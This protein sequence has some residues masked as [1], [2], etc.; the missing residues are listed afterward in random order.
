MSF[1]FVL[2]QEQRPLDPVHPGR[3]R[4]LLRAGHA[5]VWRRYPFT[6]ILKDRTAEEQPSQPLRLKIDPGSRTT[7]LA[8]VHD[9]SGQVVWAGELTHRGEKVKENLDQRRACRR[10]RRQRLTRAAG[11]PD[12]APKATSVVGGFR[13]GD[14][15]RAVVPPSST[16][17][18]TYVGRIAIRATGSC[19]LKTASGT[20]EGIH[21]RYC[22]P[23]LRGDG[24]S[25]A[26]GAA[27]PP[28]A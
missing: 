24:Y 5:A 22:R 26:K 9:V 14:L 15:V 27:L 19:N 16:K 13:T 10:S 18:G 6:L 28:Q 17:V 21:V 4:F 11:F 23:L 20:I 12:K 1:V 2:D 3:A 25:Y 8:L 7:G